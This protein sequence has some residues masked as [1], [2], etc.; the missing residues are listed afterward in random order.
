[1]LTN[2][3]VASP[4]SSPTA[5]DHNQATA[6]ELEASLEGDCK[7]FDD[8]RLASSGS[9]SNLVV[10][11]DEAPEEHDCGRRT[12]NQIPGFARRTSSPV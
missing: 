2:R 12:L 1:M 9:I 11:G 8:S 10:A 6:R 5:V 7:P 4:N 3:F